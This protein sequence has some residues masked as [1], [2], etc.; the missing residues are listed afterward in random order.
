MMGIFIS[1]GSNS[2]RGTERRK[3]KSLL[4]LPDNYTVIDIETTGYNLKTDRIIEIS[5]IKVEND[6]EV[7]SFSSFVNPCCKIDRCIERLT[8]ITNEMLE[9][10]LEIREVLPDFLNFIGDSILLGHNVNFDINFLYDNT[11]EWL[12]RYLDNDYIDTLKFSN[13]ALP[14]L[15]GHKL[16][17]IA[18]YFDIEQK[19]SH[20]ALADCRTTLEVYK[21]LKAFIVENNINLKAPAQR[22]NIPKPQP[23]RAKDIVSENT[24]FNQSNAVFGKVFV[25]TG[26]LEKM[27]REEAMRKVVDLGGINGDNVTKKTN[28][29][30]IGNDPTS[31]N[32]YGA[33]LKDGKSSKQRKAE[34]YKLKGQDIEIISENLFYKIIE[35]IT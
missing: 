1:Y 14:E 30:V 10:A 4:T 11:L 21:E 20:R 32:Y 6:I 7:C 5:A 35:D 22:M 15:P 31:N 12:D 3:G 2:S 26:T 29:L 19:E 34:E 13:K 25:F 24:E 33:I 17:D 27:S 9:P 16:A 8:G 28:F 23:K 18:K